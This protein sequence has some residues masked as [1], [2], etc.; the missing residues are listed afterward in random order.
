MPNNYLREHNSGN[1][2][3]CKLYA[4]IIAEVLLSEIGC[5]YLK[6]LRI[7]GEIGPKECQSTPRIGAPEEFYV[8]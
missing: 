6:L 2:K 1:Y 4:N 8:F 5:S 3:Y 7:M